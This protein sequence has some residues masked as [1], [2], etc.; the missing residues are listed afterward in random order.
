MS[1][2]NHAA[3]HPTAVALLIVAALL[4]GACVQ[5][6]EETAAADPLRALA[7]AEPVAQIYRSETCV[8]CTDHVAHLEDEGFEV[9]DHV[10]ADV[11]A[12]KRDLGVPTGMWSCHTTVIGGYVVEGHV[13]AESV[14]TI[15]A[16]RPEVDGIA[17]PGMPAGSPGMPGELEGPLDIRTFSNGAD[18]GHID[19][20][21]DLR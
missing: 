13:P 1:R 20:L 6:V 4:L 19:Q 7:D 18:L 21:G 8:C 10:V 5:T 9:V 2:R 17:L 11:N 3:L 16:E 14:R 15:V 12:V